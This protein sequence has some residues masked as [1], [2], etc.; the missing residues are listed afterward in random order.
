MY[1]AEGIPHIPMDSGGK[2]KCSMCTMCYLFCLHKVCIFYNMYMHCFGQDC[3][4]RPGM[5]VAC[6]P[7]IS[8]PIFT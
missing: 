8:Q 6:H 2:I 1:E 3:H 7:G 5:K 4:R